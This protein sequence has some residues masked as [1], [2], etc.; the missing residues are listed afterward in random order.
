MLANNAEIYRSLGLS[1]DQVATEKPCI[2]LLDDDAR[3]E[4]LAPHVLKNSAGPLH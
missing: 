2:K 1:W 4:I 3:R